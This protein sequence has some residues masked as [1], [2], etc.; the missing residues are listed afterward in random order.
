MSEAAEKLRADKWLWQARFFKTRSLSA[1]LITGSH[2]RVN[3]DKVVKA[4]ATVKVGDVLTFP[5]GNHIRVIQIDGIGTRRGPAFEA[6]ALYTD[7]SPP[8]PRDIGKPYA[9]R[10]GRPSKADLKLGAQIKRGELE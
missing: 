10:G 8:Q 1:K 3:S 7:L 9:E 6:Q 2:L 4:S 5:Q